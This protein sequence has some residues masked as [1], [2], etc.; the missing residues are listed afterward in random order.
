MTIIK[1]LFTILEHKVSP[2]CHPGQAPC[3]GAQ[4]Q[5]PLIAQDNNKSPMEG[6]RYYVYILA[7]GVHG[8]L[9][10]GITNSLL[11]RIHDHKTK[12]NKSFTSKYR[13]EK[14]VYY[15]VIDGIRSAITREKQLKF[16][17]RQWK[18]NLINKFI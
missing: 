18:L 8:T 3:N 17:K 14:L 7:S 11:R 5:D 13:I 12:R 9:Y 1:I 10:I 2:E 6:K 16:W 4:V 15:E